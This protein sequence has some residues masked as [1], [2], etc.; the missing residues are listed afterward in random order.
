MYSERKTHVL[1]TED[2][3][4][5]NGAHEKKVHAGANRQVNENHTQRSNNSKVNLA[6][7]SAYF[8]LAKEVKR[9]TSKMR[10]PMP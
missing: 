9:P 5:P 3:R 6:P 1:R 10:V 7:I 8:Q 2:A 4:A